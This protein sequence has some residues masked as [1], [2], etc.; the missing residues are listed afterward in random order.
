MPW[1][2]TPLQKHG[3]LPYVLTGRAWSHSYPNEK[4]ISVILWDTI[5]T[6]NEMLIWNP[7]KKNP[8]MPNAKNILR[9]L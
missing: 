5:N 6:S 4:Q 9:P 3:I 1:H 8:V 2:F 7:D